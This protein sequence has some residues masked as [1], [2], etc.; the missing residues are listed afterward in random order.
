MFGFGCKNFM[1]ATV[2]GAKVMEPTNTH[3]HKHTHRH[4]CMHRGKIN[5]NN[6]IN[7][8]LDQ[9]ASTMKEDSKKR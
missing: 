3:S 8:P 7:Y 9:Q 5:K 1:G 2:A 4:A 6:V